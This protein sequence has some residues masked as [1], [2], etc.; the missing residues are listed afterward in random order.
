MLEHIIFED[1]CN[2]YCDCPNSQSKAIASEGF[3]ST[4]STQQIPHC[5][6]NPAQEVHVE[7]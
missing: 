7:G 3:R 2:E 5:E 1:K 4:K 6:Y